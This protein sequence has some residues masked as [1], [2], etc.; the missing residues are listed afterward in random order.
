MASQITY[1]DKV[2]MKTSSLPE[3]N[4]CTAGNLNEIKSVVN[5]NA[6]ELEEVNTQVSQIIESG[7]NANGNYVKYADGTM[8]CYKTEIVTTALNKAWGSLYQAQDDVILLGNYAQTFLDVPH[9]QATVNNKQ[10]GS[11]AI[12]ARIADSTTTSFGGIVLLR[13]VSTQSVNYN[14]DLMAIGKWK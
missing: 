8:I 12:I 10:N 4:K 14:I 9:I 6:T 7:S 1:D 13:P 3:E 11:G 5:A 2:S